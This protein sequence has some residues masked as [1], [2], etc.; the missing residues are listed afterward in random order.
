MRIRKLSQYELVFMNIMR[1]VYFECFLSFAYG[2]CIVM[3][4]L[5]S[6]DIGVKSSAGFNSREITSSHGETYLTRLN[7]FSRSLLSKPEYYAPQMMLLIS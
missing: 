2:E 5:I 7:M 3:F 1:G 6:L 4:S